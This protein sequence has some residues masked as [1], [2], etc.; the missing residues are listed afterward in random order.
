MKNLPDH[1]INRAGYEQAIETAEKTELCAVLEGKAHVAYAD[2]EPDRGQ[3][4]CDISGDEEIADVGQ[5]RDNRGN[6]RPDTNG[7]F[8]CRLQIFSGLGKVNRYFLRV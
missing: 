4:S 1:V 7:G 3:R 2:G 8:R 6:R 5:E